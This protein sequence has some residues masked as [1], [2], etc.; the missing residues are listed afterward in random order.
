MLE[1]YNKTNK[2]EIK[3]TI[4]ALKDTAVNYEHADII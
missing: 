4:K 2:S 3:F 1:S